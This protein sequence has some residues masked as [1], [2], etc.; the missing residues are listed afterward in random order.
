MVLS[1]PSADKVPSQVLNLAEAILEVQ[2][3]RGFLYQTTVVDSEG[4]VSLVAIN[5]CEGGLSI[6]IADS[7][8]QAGEEQNNQRLCHT[9][10]FNLCPLASWL[11]GLILHEAVAEFSPRVRLEFPLG[12]A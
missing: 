10:N 3:A 4:L 5:H 9:G 7:S 8:W 12:P 6:G 2:E 1:S 11:P